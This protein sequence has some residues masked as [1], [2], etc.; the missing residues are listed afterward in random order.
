MLVLCCSI[1]FHIREAE[2][3]QGG[4]KKF[5][6]HLLIFSI[7]VLKY[8]YILFSVTIC[9]QKNQTIRDHF[10]YRGEESYQDSLWIHLIQQ[11]RWDLE[12][13]GNIVTGSEGDN[14]VF[15]V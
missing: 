6:T 3:R 9:V 2:M 1:C 14:G 8:I 12:E 5:F 15:G 10:L 4:K 11:G 7:S 13:I